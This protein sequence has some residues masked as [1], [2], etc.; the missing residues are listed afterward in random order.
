[1]ELSAE[2]AK[3]NYQILADYYAFDIENE[4]ALNGK[5]YG[6]L[7]DAYAERIQALISKGI[8]EIESRDG[9]VYIHHNLTR[10][11]PKP[12][13]S[14]ITYKPMTGKIKMAQ[15]RARD[16]EKTL[17]IVAGMAGVTTTD[18]EGLDLPD[19]TV[20]ESVVGPYFLLL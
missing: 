12:L 14:R 18:L 6:K 10:E 13:G 2:T 8:L 3:E 19:F 1:M 7:I 17:C 15:K 5:E 11:Y 9:R 4:C 20:A 16:E